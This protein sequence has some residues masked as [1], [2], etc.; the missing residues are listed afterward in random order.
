MDVYE[1][2][3]FEYDFEPDDVCAPRWHNANGIAKECGMYSLNG[4]PHGQAAAR[5]LKDVICIGE[6]H[7][8]IETDYYGFQVGISTLY[9]DNALVAVMQWLVDNELP[10]S[11]EIHG[12]T[13]R[14]QYVNI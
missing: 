8:R 10:E 7:K 13:Y 1:P 11:I 12:T 4:K 2:F 6:E 9:D 3:G 14:V 5:I